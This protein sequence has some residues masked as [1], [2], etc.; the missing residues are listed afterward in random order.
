MCQIERSNRSEQRSR[1]VPS[2]PRPD[3]PPPD[4][5]TFLKAGASAAVAASTASLAG[6][7]PGV[8]RL[9]DSSGAIAG[10]ALDELSLTVLHAASPSDSSRRFASARRRPLPPTPPGGVP[11]TRIRSR[12]WVATVLT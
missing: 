2:D 12:P 6:C 11:E 3:A 9:A 5:R 8:R 7:E 4:R 10:G 1:N